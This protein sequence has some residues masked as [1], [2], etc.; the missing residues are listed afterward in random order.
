M[1]AGALGQ[2]TSPPNGEGFRSD[3]GRLVR[4]ERTGLGGWSTIRFARHTCKARM[5]EE[6]FLSNHGSSDGVKLTIGNP[7]PRS[8]WVVFF[9]LWN[10][11]PGP[12]PPEDVP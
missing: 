1:Q 7:Q 9:T 4:D 12:P 10:I 2:A 8:V 5:C 11:H 6:A 3:H